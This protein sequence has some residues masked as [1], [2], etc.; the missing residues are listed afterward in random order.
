MFIPWSSCCSSS[1]PLSL[2][3]PSVYS[4]WCL[5][6]RS[7]SLKTLYQ[8]YAI[9]AAKLIYDS[10]AP[11]Q[12]HCVVL[13]RTSVNLRTWRIETTSI[14]KAP[15]ARPIKLIHLTV[16]RYPRSF[17]KGI[18]KCATLLSNIGG[19]CEWWT[20][21]A[22]VRPKSSRNWINLR[23]STCPSGTRR[24]FFRFMAVRSFH[25]SESSFDLD[26]W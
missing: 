7:N 21:V 6:I 12:P 11:A 5:M 1:A 4:K 8:P 23:G 17:E 16:F 24:S 26:V 18:R 13:R 9:S 14:G 15:N 3:R 25:E 19:W 20:I 2:S 10:A 22:S